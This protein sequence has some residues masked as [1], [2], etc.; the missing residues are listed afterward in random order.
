VFVVVLLRVV[1][2]L[3]FMN[4]C[5]F[6]IPS[7]SGARIFVYDKGVNIPSTSLSFFYFHKKNIKIVDEC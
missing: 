5:I 7:T 1:F 6:V 4:F 3:V 2:T